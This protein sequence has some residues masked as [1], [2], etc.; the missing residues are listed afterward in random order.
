MGRFI[1]SGYHQDVPRG[2]VAF[3]FVA[4]TLFAAA[5]AC[6]APVADVADPSSPQ[7][8]ATNVRRTEVADAQRIIANNPTATL[9]AAPT[10]LA[11]PIC[12]AQ[13]AIWWYEARAHT[14]ES[15]TVQGT[16]VATRPAP[17]G[18]ALLEIGQPYPDPTGLAVLLPATSASPAEGKTVCVAGRITMVEGRSTMQLRDASSILVMN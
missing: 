1:S 6:G 10:A 17:A 13:G 14:G 3:A 2:L 11:P 15:R 12:Q 4:I 16:I 7:A 8:H 9:R 5:A 18:L